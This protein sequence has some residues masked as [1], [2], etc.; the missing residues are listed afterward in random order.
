MVFPFLKIIFSNFV[1]FWVVL[2]TMLSSSLI[3][4]RESQ[5]QLVKAELLGWGWGDEIKNGIKVFSGGLVFAPPSPIRKI[6]LSFI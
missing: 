5:T 3:T 2:I 1:S 4:Y 6:K